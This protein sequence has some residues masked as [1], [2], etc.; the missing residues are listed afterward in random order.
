MNCIEMKA[1]IDLRAKDLFF[2]F[3]NNELE[4]SEW[5]NCQMMNEGVYTLDIHTWENSD[6]SIGNSSVKFKVETLDECYDGCTESVSFYIPNYFLD[7][8]L[9]EERVIEWWTNYQKA[10]TTLAQWEAIDRVIS[11]ITIQNLEIVEKTVNA[12]KKL[13]DTCYVLPWQDRRNLFKEIYGEI[14]VEHANNKPLF[15]E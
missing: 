7:E 10:T 6:G 9:D 13:K 3:L 14:P 15:N 12:L 2:I 4:D 1:F 5:F 8:I 11:N